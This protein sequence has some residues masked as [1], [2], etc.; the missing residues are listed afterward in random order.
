MLLKRLSE[1]MGGPGHEG[2]VRNLL[3][4]ELKDC[5]DEIRTDTIGNLFCIKKGRP[6][7]LK[8][9][10]AAHMDEVALMITHIEKNGMLRVRNAG[11]IDD[12]ILVS[13]IVRVGKDKIPG[14]IGAKA[15]HLQEPHERN[16]ALKTD[17]LYLDIG[18]KSKEEA[19]KFTKMG[20]YAYFETTFEE[21]GN[22]M[23]KGKALDDRVGCY[24][25]AELLKKQWD[26]TF[27]GVFTVQEEVGL[28][29]AG[30]AAFALQPDMAL[31]LEGTT[32]SDVPESEEHEQNTTVGAGPAIS[33]IDRAGIAT[34]SM[35][36]G[37]VEVAEKHGIPYQLRRTNFGGTDA[38]RINTTGAGIPAATVAV[39]CRYIH[40]PVSI[41][42]SKD[43]EN[44][45]KLAEYYLRSVEQGG[46]K[47]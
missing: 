19:E 7:A 40:S 5:V 27:C 44:T 20:D 24:I 17:H 2:E 37:L 30:V 26:F 46:V 3:R 16:Q 8:V 36:K 21:F 32:A 47:A 18:A 4:E 39:P 28:R 29:G 10:V 6:G 35:V 42:S 22:G 15:I 45:L 41:A 14:V 34:K 12:R 23:I 11:G 38:G 13:K 33:V 1:A 9:M 43:L 31:V 25:L